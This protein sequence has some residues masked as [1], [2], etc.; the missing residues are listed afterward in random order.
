MNPPDRP[1]RIILG[2]SGASGA[3]YG[4]RL[5]DV[6]ERAG[7]EVHAIATAVAAQVV[8]QE[9]TVV[10]IDTESLLGRPAPRVGWHDNDRWDSPLASASFPS[11]GMAVC[12]CSSHTVASLAAGLGDNLLLRA[13]YVTLKQRRPLVLV[14]RE[15]PLTLIDLDNLRRLAAAGATICPASPGFYHHPRTIEDLIDSVV[16]RVLDLLGV[17][18]S[19]PVRWAPGASPPGEPAP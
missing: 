10:R 7:C 5:L 19:L 8:R 16:A 6:L 17:P 13:A 12:P 2:L 9:L 3:A 1:R 14:H 4:R 18:H 15:M 11:D